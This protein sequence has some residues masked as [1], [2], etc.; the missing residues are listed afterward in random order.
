M[1]ASGQMTLRAIITEAALGANRK[2]VAVIQ[3]RSVKNPEIII[4]EVTYWFRVR[5]PLDHA[6]RSYREGRK[7]NDYINASALGQEKSAAV[8][9]EDAATAGPAVPATGENTVS[10]TVISCSGLSARRPGMQPSAYVT[11]QLP[12]PE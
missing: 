8:T 2:Q 3:L 12:L 1:I 7:A 6:I 9:Q 10:I 11:P 5:L 4:V